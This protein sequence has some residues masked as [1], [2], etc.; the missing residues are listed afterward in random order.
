L[1]VDSSPPIQSHEGLAVYALH[2]P[3]NRWTPDR[4]WYD[5]FEI[6]NGRTAVLIGD[7]TGTPAEVESLTLAVR[8]AF[9]PDVTAAEANLPQVADALFCHQTASTLAAV[10]MGIMDPVE[11]TFTYIS[12]G[13]P[14]PFV[15]YH[16]GTVAALPADGLPVGLARREHPTAYVVVD[17]HDAAFL[18]L[19]SNGLVQAAKNSTAGLHSLRNVLVDERITHCGSNPAAWI[20][21]RVLGERSHDEVALLAFRFA[22]RPPEP[23]AEADAD[24]VTAGSYPRWSM[25][26]SFEATGPASNGARR[27]FLA[28]LRSKENGGKTLD[29]TAAELIFGELLGNVVRHAPGLVEV[30]LDWN[31][32]F[33]VLHV[34]DAGPGFRSRRARERL[35]VDALSESG[36]GLFIINACA[37]KFS[38]RNRKGRGTHA[39]A[40]LPPA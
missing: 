6:S 27:V 32:E 8:A 16:D 2:I 23:E 15:R 13:H 33:P 24:A 21:E 36:R 28:C 19:Y 10:T 25:S 20:A 31:E 34:L 37:T 4:A 38:V 26:W 18:V 30:T 3:A 39:C 14:P 5:A 11:Q 40:T 35:P 22:L 9:S 29:Y 12:A 17:L 7:I 1:R